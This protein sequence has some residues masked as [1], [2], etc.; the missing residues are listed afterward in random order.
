M[1]VMELSFARCE[2]SA[3]ANGNHSY[4]E[5][6]LVIFM[7]HWRAALGSFA[8]ILWLYMFPWFSQFRAQEWPLEQPG[9]SAVVWFLLVL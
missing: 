7:L 4:F 5:L 9:F 1:P 6:F 2:R 3:F 8:S